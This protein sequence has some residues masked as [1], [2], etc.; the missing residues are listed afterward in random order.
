[1]ALV[2]ERAQNV[3]IA[4]LSPTASALGVSAGMTL[5]SARALVPELSASPLDADAD[6]QALEGLGLWAQWL[7]PFVALYQH[8][9]LLIEVGGSAHLHG[10]ELA[11][12]REAQA[13]LAAMGYQAQAACADTP[14]AAWAL[15]GM[16]ELLS[17]DLTGEAGGQ[18]SDSESN[19]DRS[20]RARCTTQQELDAFLELLKRKRNEGADQKAD[21]SAESSHAPRYAALSAPRHQTAQALARLP[22]EALGLSEAT[23]ESLE[24][25]GVR[26][27]QHLLG[28]GRSQ[29]A[30]R[31]DRELSSRI[32]ELLGETPESLEIL[33]DDAPLAEEMRF[34]QPLDDGLH[35][36]L[37]QLCDRLGEAL[38]GAAS[39]TRELKLSFFHEDADATHHSVRASEAIGNAKGLLL[40]LT[41][42]LE[43]HPPTRAITGARLAADAPEALRTRDADLFTG[44]QR[45]R[46]EGVHDLL[47]RLSARLGSSQV[48]RLELLENHQPELA[49]RSAPVLG[50]KSARVTHELKLRP[51]RVFADP[52]PVVVHLRDHEPAS[53]NRHRLL[54]V[55][56]PER[57]GG[58]W[59]SDSFARDYYRVELD[60]GE[61]YWIYRDRVTGSFYWQ[62]VFG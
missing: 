43:S 9:A 33:R 45:A 50:A 34:E 4:S 61:W 24:D 8:D 12:M 42:Y 55:E 16:A 57:L 28:L 1:M 22:V 37:K 13:K 59:W 14:R 3:R 39:G 17:G 52:V 6:R 27:L 26:T 10:G 32:A 31:F 21:E 5:A 40:L 60:N 53:L 18:R 54:Q 25:F 58:N 36:V 44:R 49:W 48:T 15:A 2:E 7:G 35:F 46:S 56:G 62:G 47:D 30:S 41:T 29:L 19:S 20:T 51:L 23:L 38:A 11:A